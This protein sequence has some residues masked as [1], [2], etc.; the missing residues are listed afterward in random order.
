MAE[1]DLNLL[2]AL[3]A[4]LHSR[5]VTVAARQIGV[6]QPTMSGMLGRLRDQLHD[7][8]LVRV[9]KSMQLTKRA[10]ALLPEVRQML[11][12]AE[13]LTLDPGPFE[14]ENLERRFTMMTSEFGLFIIFPQVMDQMM[15]TA[16]GVQFDIS[17]IDQ[18]VESVYSGKVDL[19]V[20]GD[21]IDDIGG[22]A[23]RSV[24]TKTLMTDR[25]VA[26]VDNDHPLTGRIGLDEL[27]AYPHVATQFLGSKRAVEDVGSRNLSNRHPPR[28]RVPSFLSIAPMVAGTHSIGIVPARLA[29]R[30]CCDADVR[31]LVLS[32]E[33]AEIAIKMLWH[34]RDDHDAAHAWLRGMMVARCQELVRETAISADAH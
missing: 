5:N 24:R 33:F 23:A 7:P 12:A 9:G 3:D 20:T 30:L 8:L 34:I 19:C 10:G 18:P 2:P 14:P 13:K 31:P 32:D 25:F 16:K 22:E 28:V 21:L 1:L 27:L 6:S 26:I 17:A 4:L 11:L 15:A 29:P